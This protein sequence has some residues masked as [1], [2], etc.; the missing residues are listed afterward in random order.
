MEV[1][2]KQNRPAIF[3]HGR[4]NTVVFIIFF[5]LST[6]FTFP[7]LFQM[8]TSFYGQHG[9]PSGAMWWGWWTR[10][11]N[12]N[13]MSFYE[14]PFLSAPFG[15][16]FRDLAE[17]AIQKYV[18]NQFYYLMDEV[19]FWNF[20]TFLGY[21][22]SA[23]TMYY[24]IHHITRERWSSLFGAI[25]FSFCPYHQFHAYQHLWLATTQWI[26]LYVLFFIKLIDEPGRDWRKLKWLIRASF[27][28]FAFALVFNE[29]Y[30][31]GYFSIVF[32]CLFL[33]CYLLYQSIRKGKLFLSPR[34]LGVALVTGIL[35]L[36][37]T[38]PFTMPI[39]KA[40]FLPS[41]SVNLANKGY[42][43]DFSE[44]TVYGASLRDY[45]IPSIDHPLFG[46]YVQ[47]YL[48][49][50]FH[51]SNLFEH[52][53]FLGY[54]PLFLAFY[55]IYSCWKKSR[56]KLK[57]ITGL[58][59]PTDIELP[60][61][62]FLF[63]FT[64]IGM[65][66]FS[67][68]PNPVILGVK[69]YMPSYFLYDL[70]PMFRVYSR[71]GLFVILCTGVLAGVGFYYM[72]RQTNSKRSRVLISALLMGGTLF[73]FMNFP[74]AKSTVASEIPPA[75]Q[76]LCT[77]PGDFI[78]AEYPMVN[79]I[80]VRQYMYQF[81][82]RIHKK[83]MVNGARLGTIGEAIRKRI[84]D[85]DDPDVPQVLAFLNTKYVIVHRD[86]YKEGRLPTFLHRYY[87]PTYYA[88][89][90]TEY[91]G[92]NPPDLSQKPGFTKAR[93]FGDT[94]VY[95]VAAAPS[96][97]LML[98][99]DAFAKPE[100]WANETMWRWMG[101]DGQLIVVNNEK[102]NSIVSMGF[103]AT[104]FFK[105]RRLSVSFNR[106]DRR[107]LEIDKVKRRFCIENV[108]LEPGI[109]RIEFSTPDGT[110]NIDS[111]L[112]NGD[113]RNVSIAI[114]DI[115]FGKQCSQRLPESVLDEVSQC[116][117]MPKGGVGFHDW[118]IWSREIPSWAE[119]RPKKFRW[120]KER[121][122]LPIRMAQSTERT[123]E[124]KDRRKDGWV[125]FLQCSHPNIDEEPVV[126]KVRVDGKVV[127]EEEFGD[128]RW[129]KV[130]L[131]GEELRDKRI[132]TFEVSRTW[133]PKIA[134]VS[135]DDRDLGVAVA[136]P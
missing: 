13:S 67:A 47:R 23:L 48:T 28:A 70:F 86:I 50:R 94:V 85:L 53:L 79:N 84:I 9:D 60:K 115:E 111:V 135:G 42:V 75:Y 74:P 129:K 101:N 123:H 78:I 41:E 91:S 39:I 10:Y 100:E 33:I 128:H 52:T 63:T 55:A 122:S 130:V 112:R 71:F 4:L 136:I 68:P 126:V 82:Q 46:P 108:R 87:G 97:Y 104:S 83:R 72:L 116:Y 61:W 133:N 113:Q 119:G 65:M 80:E 21:F 27:C 121:A 58:T 127:R 40:S 7:L 131:K 96:Q 6:A 14:T 29:N 30:Y 118:E 2:K 105:K 56:K 44:L 98:W 134:G 59:K 62:V 76:W 25:T 19:F 11:S 69:L 81:Y 66:V 125:M 37:F 109:N 132:L 49:N 117:H 73:E 15:E 43:R 26:P 51:G 12:A 31:Y 36:L 102:E 20:F 22:I 99:G 106:T 18:Y 110:E 92:G 120:S 90:P 35:C 16:D 1:L 64:G 3:S 34:G 103:N 8:N 54:I 24:L 114:G 57:G 5:L 77:E 107:V 32:S 38:L 45:L 88:S 95:Q 17:Q 89:F 124:K 93:D